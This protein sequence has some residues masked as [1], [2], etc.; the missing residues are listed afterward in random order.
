MLIVAAAMVGLPLM[1]YAQPGRFDDDPIGGPPG[2]RDRIERRVHTMKM[3]KL[4]EELDLSE[5]QA[6][7]FIPMM[8]EMERKMEEVQ[9]NRQETLRKLGD[10]AWEE[11]SKP[12]EIN[13]LLDNLEN[14]EQQQ[15][16]LRRQFRKDAAGVLKP[17]QMGRMV[18]FNLRFADTMRDAIREFEERRDMPPPPP[19]R[20]RDW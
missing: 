7:R 20:R 8:N 19:P 14:L 16:D 1:G 2:R 17:D 11:K 5:E 4:T 9:R 13:K 18:L 6:T 3:W 15:M 10:L 12:E